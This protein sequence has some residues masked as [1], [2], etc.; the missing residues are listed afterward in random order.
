MFFL[1][2]LACCIVFIVNQSNA[3]DHIDLTDINPHEIFPPPLNELLAQ[4]K[5]SLNLSTADIEEE[6]FEEFCLT[7]A[8]KEAEQLFLL[9][10][11]GYLLLPRSV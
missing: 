11:N 7:S 8:D 9:A 1:L 10:S 5:T 2:K 6:S 3:I 4:L